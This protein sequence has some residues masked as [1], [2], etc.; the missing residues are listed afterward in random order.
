MR[1]IANSSDFFKSEAVRAEAARLTVKSA[2]HGPPIFCVH[3]RAGG[4]PMRS[5][6]MGSTQQAWAEGAAVEAGAP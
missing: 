5:G 2:G 6:E 3:E 1:E 4:S